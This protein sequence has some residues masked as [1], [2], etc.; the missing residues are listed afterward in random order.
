MV[1]P[2]PSCVCTERSEHFGRMS[3]DKGEGRIGVGKQLR[4]SRSE[5][6]NATERRKCM[7]GG[8]ETLACGRMRRVE[9][10]M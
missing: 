2:N 4:R 6:A 5:C 10:R 9:G 3:M 8:A 1:E 7:T